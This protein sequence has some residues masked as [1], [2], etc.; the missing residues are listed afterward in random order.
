[1][2]ILQVLPHLSKGGAERVVVELSNS[3]IVDDHEVTLL[4]A[5]P[6]NPSLNQQYLSHKINIQFVSEGSRNRLL[7]Y[8]KLPFYILKNWK[9]L[10]TFDAIH[11]H[12]SFGLVFGS[13]CSIFR[14]ITKAKNLRIIATCHVVGGGISQIRRAL[15]ERLSYFFDVF[16]LMA[17]DAHWRNFISSK[18]RNNIQV[19]VNGISADSWVRAIK[20]T[21]DA[22]ALTIGTISRLQRERKPWLFLEVFAHL[23]ELTH[24]R[25][26]FV[27]GGDGPEKKNLVE[28]SKKFKL[29]SLLSMPGL[30]HNPKE[31]L[32]SIDLYVGLNVEEVTGI[33]ALEAVFFGI[34]TVSIQLSP[35]YT[36]G[37]EDWI[38]SDQDP[39]LVAL[40]IARLLDKPE[41]LSKVASNQFLV[42]IRDY[43][44]LRMRDNYLDLYSGN[45]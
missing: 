28:L 16:A 2:R 18:K 42:A 38:W 9:I 27:I 25:V 19:V 39:Q 4:L 32:G 43:S 15:N 36:K 11:C 45:A 26:Q 31:L 40:E 22:H 8:L 12:L 29:T 1:M 37:K 41:N 23:K 14:R 20:P 35:D 6:V 24:G 5:F 30:I 33:A 34:P 17:Q 10:K 44:I 3:L 21:R 13:L 7:V